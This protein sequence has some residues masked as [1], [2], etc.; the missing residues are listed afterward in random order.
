MSHPVA[1]TPPSLCLLGQSH[2]KILGMPR[3]WV[4]TLDAWHFLYSKHVDCYV[5]V[6]E[7]EDFARKGN[8]LAEI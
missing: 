3:T 5:A 8:V 4:W 6:G 7:D 1:L 2:D